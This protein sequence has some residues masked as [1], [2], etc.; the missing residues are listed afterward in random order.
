MKYGVKYLLELLVSCRKNEK[1]AD[2][3][4]LELFIAKKR[5][6]SEKQIQLPLN[7]KFLARLQPCLKANKPKFRLPEYFEST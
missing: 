7:A 1:Q 2:F 3:Q 6:L 4:V 5:D